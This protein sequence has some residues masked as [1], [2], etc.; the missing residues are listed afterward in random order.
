M[1]E[2]EQDKD[3]KDNLIVNLQV[4][5]QAGLILIVRAIKRKSTMDSGFSFR[6]SSNLNRLLLLILYDSPP[7]NLVMS[8]SEVA[9]YRAL[10]PVYTAICSVAE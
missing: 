10:K 8:A 5:C 7:S 1:E 6:I 9:V 3:K 2:V 4:Q